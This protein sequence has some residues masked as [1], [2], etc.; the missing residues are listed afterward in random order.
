M[1]PRKGCTV[2]PCISQHSVP[3]ESPRRATS[4]TYPRAIVRHQCV[5]IASSTRAQR[6]IKAPSTR[7]HER[8]SATSAKLRARSNRSLASHGSV[9]P[10]GTSWDLMG[11]HGTSWSERLQRF[12]TLGGVGPHRPKPRS[13]PKPRNKP[14]SR[15]KPKLG[16]GLPC[17]HGHAPCNDTPLQ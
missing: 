13:K 6:V 14:K 16:G 2:P 4:G 5:I 8:S 12:R 9:G 15:S 1:E 10:H 3:A 7:P 11:S 17:P